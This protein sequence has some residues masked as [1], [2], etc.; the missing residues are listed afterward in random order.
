MLYLM[1]GE[2]IH[3]AQSTQINPTAI[4]GSTVMNG[5][6]AEDEVLLMTGHYAFKKK[7]L[8]KSSRKTSI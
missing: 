5:T 7:L 4:C 6:L 1:A 3:V 8:G 2:K